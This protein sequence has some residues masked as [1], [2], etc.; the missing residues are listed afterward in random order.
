MQSKFSL[1]CTTSRSWTDKS[2]SRYL[3]GDLQLFT[4]QGDGTDAYL[5]ISKFGSVGKA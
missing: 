3:G 1:F 4:I 2:A 5:T